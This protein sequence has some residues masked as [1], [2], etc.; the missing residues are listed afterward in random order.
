MGET[1]SLDFSTLLAA[2]VHDMKNSVGMLSHLAAELQASGG[3]DPRWGQIDL[4]VARLNSYLM[5]LMTLYK[6]QQ[7]QYRGLTLEHYLDEFVDDLLVSQRAPLQARGIRVRQQVPAGLSWEFDGQLVTGALSTILTNV[8]HHRGAE[9]QVSAERVRV[10]DE[11]YL[12]LR[13]EDDGAGF[14]APMLGR[15]EQVSLGVNFATG[16]TGFGL[17]FARQVALV[18]RQG[19]RRGYVELANGGALGGGCFQLYL[20]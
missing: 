12:C 20:P 9:V 11:D 1:G 10:A 4:E 2:S 7:Q 13:I 15:L 3:G 6:L 14:P 8:I 5:Q 16:S 18:H 19:T 17:Y